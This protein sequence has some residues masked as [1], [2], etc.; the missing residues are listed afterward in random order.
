MEG[1]A[2]RQGG[3]G[4]KGHS[5]NGAVG[6]SGNGAKGHSGNG[7]TGHSGNGAKGHSSNRGNGAQQQWGRSGN[8]GNR[9]KAAA[10]LPKARLHALTASRP[11]V[12]YLKCARAELQWRRDCSA[13]TGGSGVRHKVRASHPACACGPVSCQLIRPDSCASKSYI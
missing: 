10:W 7:A 8:G 9:G 13:G 12:A 1:R 11:L 5:G 2:E 6:H 4:A 3:N